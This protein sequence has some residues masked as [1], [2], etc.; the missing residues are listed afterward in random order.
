MKIV[1]VVFCVSLAMMSNHAFSG[2]AHFEGKKTTCHVFKQD[3]LVKQADCTLSGTGYA[4]VY[5]AGIDY[6]L[7]IKNYGVFDIS[8][9]VESLQENDGGYQQPIDQFITLLN[10]DNA[11][12]QGRDSNTFQPLSQYEYQKRK[13]IWVE[14]IANRK[15]KGLPNYLV[16]Y[17]NSSIEICISDKYGLF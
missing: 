2:A 12:E 15:D 1:K 3:K 9:S 17:I 8:A 16:C 6:Q 13:E 4:N 7:E 11:V 10:N 5:S 14:K